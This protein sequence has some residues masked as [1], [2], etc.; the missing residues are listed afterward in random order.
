MAG[1]G[2]EE[3]LGEVFDAVAEA[4]DRERPGYPDE[5]IDAACTIGELFAGSRVLEVGCGTGKLTEAL[6][7][8]GLVVDAVDPGANMIAVARRR[9]RDSDRVTF[10]RARFEELPL[11]EQP[12]DAVFSAAAFHW[13]DPRV[14][15]AKSARSLRAGGMLA[16]AG[17][18]SCWDESTAADDEAL[19]DIF[20]RRWDTGGWHPLR[21]PATL[22]AGVTERR[23]NVSTVWTWLGQNDVES[24][25]AAI[26]FENVQL[27]AHHLRREQTAD[28]LWGLFA[29]TSLYPRLDPG[30]R[31]ALESE[32]RAYV[33]QRG[34]IVRTSE[35]A[36]L[37][38]ASRS[39]Q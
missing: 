16:L 6:V 17:H 13:I 29:T 19:R 32:I 25:E 24:P 37:V 10:H 14:G 28:R 3:R 15:W 4:Y 1:D 5:L 7:G 11:P 30:S 21:D 22:R 2:A 27:T 20:G 26:L 9:V 31:A 8:R 39:E 34:G 12:F 38:T 35:L 23:D 36:I 18:I 33:E